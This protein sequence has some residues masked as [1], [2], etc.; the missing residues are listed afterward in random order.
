MHHTNWR[1]TP[2]EAGVAFGKTLRRAQAELPGLWRLCEEKYALGQASMRLCQTLWPALSEEVEGIAEG[3]GLRAMDVAA[4]L[5]SIYCFPMA[6]HCS[7]FALRDSGQV[8]LARNSDFLKSIAPA[9]D[10]PFYQLDGTIPFLGS[11]TSFTQIE[12]GVNRHGLAAGLTMVYP[13]EIQP[14][15]NAGLLVRYVLEHCQTVEEALAALAQLPVSSAQTIVLADAHGDLA[16]VECNCRAMHVQRPQGARAFVA[17]VNLFTSDILRPFDRP[18]VPNLQAARRQ[19]TLCKVLPT[20]PCTVEY[21]QEVLAGSHGFLCQP[22]DPCLPFATVWSS[23]Y[24]LAAGHVCRAEGD[25]AQVP[26]LPD[27]RLA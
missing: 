22:A 10:S 11:T 5:F 12:D 16:A 15:L 7:C 14:G 26:F 25:P 24:D 19:D 4:F 2:Y 21:A 17:R 18:D 1:G 20:A 9:Y 6:P 13:K 8:L 23:V 27:D 3:A